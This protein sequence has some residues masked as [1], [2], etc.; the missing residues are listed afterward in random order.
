MTEFDYSPSKWI[1]FRDKKV[2][3]R[4]RNIKR[5]DIEKHPNPDFKI[6]VIPDDDLRFIFM[7]D[8][9]HRIKTASE[10]GE[11]VVL[12]TP[13]P[14]HDYSNVAYLINKFRVNCEKL[15]TFN[16]DEWADENG[17]IA[18]ETY[19]QGFMRA[20]KNYFYLKIDEDLRPPED[21]V[22]GPTT[23]NINDYGKMIA[24]MG[25]ADACYSGSGWA[26][27]IAFI[28]PDT[29]EF[30]A[31]SLEEWKKMGPRVVTLNPFTIAQNSLHGSFGMSGDMG[32]VPPRA[33][34]IGP[35][36]VIASK[37]RMDMN[38]LTVDGTSVSWQRMITRLIAHGPVTPQVPTSL[39][40]TLPT[41]FYITETLAQNIEPIW[42][43]GY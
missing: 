42:D 2:L 30:A 43:K 17:N 3:E 11:N 23:K 41:D 16:M 6:R 20:F 10:A 34:T 32:N 36:D 26:G 24:D 4:V 33:A 19:P 8:M 40:Q 1:P 28:D 27:H 39:L 13:N 7:T 29:P 38:G 5:Q 37:Y 25:N 18:P 35:A 15:Y 14:C 9:F 22:Q 21:H 31:D 12:I